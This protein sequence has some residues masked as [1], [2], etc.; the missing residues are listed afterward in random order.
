MT[1]AQ[2]RSF[3]GFLS[4][5]HPG[6]RL[7]GLLI[8]CSHASFSSFTSFPQQW[9]FTWGCGHPWA[10]SKQNGCLGTLICKEAVFGLGL[11]IRM[12]GWEEAMPKAQGAE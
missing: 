12:A 5:S 8:S 3:L 11:V 2:E 1:P 6:F 7:T 4:C 9:Q 10:L